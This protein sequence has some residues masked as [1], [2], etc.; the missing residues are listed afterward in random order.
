MTIVTV[1]V[2]VFSCLQVIR[3]VH[4]FQANTEIVAL[5]KIVVKT[6]TFLILTDYLACYMCVCVAYTTVSKEIILV[7][8][9]SSITTT[10]EIP[11]IKVQTLRELRMRSKLTTIDR[12]GFS[13]CLPVVSRYSLLRV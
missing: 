13:M 1:C 3:N 9:E 12:L 4:R 5:N 7:L 2:C 11:A 6:C 10:T 8:W